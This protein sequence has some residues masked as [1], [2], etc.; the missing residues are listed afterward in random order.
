LVGV[1]PSTWSA[2]SAFQGHT[3]HTRIKFIVILCKASSFA[4]QI[5]PLNSIKDKIM[6]CD[7]NILNKMTKDQILEVLTMERKKNSI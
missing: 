3:I 2:V 5:S 1:K 4:F 6:I 7:P